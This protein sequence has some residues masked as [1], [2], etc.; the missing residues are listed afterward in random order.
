MS[1]AASA[2][3]A[4]SMHEQNRKPARRPS[5]A[6][7]RL[8]SAVSAASARYSLASSP[9]ISPGGTG[10][11]GASST[12]SRAAV[13]SPS[14]PRP[15]ASRSGPR[16]SPS[17][18]SSSRVPSS[19]TQVSACASRM[20]STSSRTPPT[21]TPELPPGTA[22][23]PSRSSRRPGSTAL[24]PGQGGARSRPGASS[25]LLIIK[26]VLRCQPM[27]MLRGTDA[28]AAATGDYDRVSPRRLGHYLKAGELLTPRGRLAARRLRS[29]LPY[30]AAAARRTRVTLSPSSPR[31]MQTSSTWT[32]P[33]PARPA[34]RASTA[35]STTCSAIPQ[36]QK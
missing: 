5:S 6:A 2:K 32:R 25:L 23:R 26:L 35:S 11:P 21:T 13:P 7:F 34:T 31:G 30:S 3:L 20:S 8:T 14:T 18:P 10:R 16:I 1:Y 9:S 12:P 22:P 28:R 24:W 29:T 19:P 33:I 15:R 36:T 27:S 4:C 17:A